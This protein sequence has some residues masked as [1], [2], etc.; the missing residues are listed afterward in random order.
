MHNEGL[1]TSTHATLFRLNQSRAT[2][3]H[4]QGPCHWKDWDWGAGVAVGRCIAPMQYDPVST[5]A[6]L[7]TC[8]PSAQLP[9]PWH[10]PC[11]P[12]SMPARSHTSGRRPP[13][14]PPAVPPHSRTPSYPPLPTSAHL[15]DLHN[16][17]TVPRA[18]LHVFGVC[19]GG[20]FARRQTLAVFVERAC[21]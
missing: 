18:H 20:H 10:R 21:Q 6:V 1:L 14:R 15:L 3:V 8:T 5:T 11:T 12:L 9:H 16:V 2:H 7:H 17:R 4:V 13:D 19:V